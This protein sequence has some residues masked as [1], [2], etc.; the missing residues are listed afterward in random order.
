M[1]DAASKKEGGKILMVTSLDD[2]HPCDNIIDGQEASYWMSTGL[3]PQEILVALKGPCMISTIKLA[4]TNVKSVRIEGCAE[5]KPVNFHVLAE[6][7]LEE[8][9]GSIQI[10]DLKVQDGSTTASFVKLQILSGY[11]DF[12]SVHTIKVE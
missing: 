5:E 10:K 12:C 1:P 8:K 7:D 2:G 9:G 4:T 11:H 6:G 3:Y